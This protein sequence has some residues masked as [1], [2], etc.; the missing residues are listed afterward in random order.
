MKLSVKCVITAR[1]I[2]LVGGGD[3]DDCPQDWLYRK[4]FFLSICKKKKF[5]YIARA[6]AYDGGV[7]SRR[8]FSKICMKNVLFNDRVD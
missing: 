1:E 5:N 6:R 3:D 4:I 2:R 8:A 7:Q